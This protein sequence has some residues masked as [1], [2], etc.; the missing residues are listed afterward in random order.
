MTV[1]K[2]QSQQM[3][4]TDFLQMCFES[5]RRSESDANNHIWEIWGKQ[6]QKTGIGP[7]RGTRGSIILPLLL[8]LL[9]LNSYESR[10]RMIAL[11]EGA[12]S[13]ATKYQAFGVIHIA[14]RGALHT[15]MY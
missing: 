2:S 14:C 8:S 4:E 9:G 7:K 15:F 10:T 5:H 1:E 11:D 12:P 13:G 6:K 3:D